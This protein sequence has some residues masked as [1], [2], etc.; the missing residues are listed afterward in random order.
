MPNNME[1]DK[2]LLT[3][4]SQKFLK[5]I[6]ILFFLIVPNVKILNN[7]NKKSYLKKKRYALINI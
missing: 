5:R 1:F 6:E 2:F 3:R 7:I 4:I